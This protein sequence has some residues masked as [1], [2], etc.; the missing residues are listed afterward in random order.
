MISCF[1]L[2]RTV[3]EK[4]DISIE[5]REEK[6]KTKI[7][8]NM[9]KSSFIEKN[10]EQL[11]YLLYWIDFQQV[12]FT[13]DKTRQSLVCMVGVNEMSCYTYKTNYKCHF[14]DGFRVYQFERFSMNVV[15]K[16]KQNTEIIWLI[17][18]FFFSKY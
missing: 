17:R 18:M 14:S 1:D 9:L 3:T 4:D 7:P 15:V 11:F 5:M 8:I 6:K 16:L 12:Q 10:V 13:Q 2:P